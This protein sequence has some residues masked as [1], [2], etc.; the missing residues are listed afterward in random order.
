MKILVIGLGQL[1][2]DLI[3]VLGPSHQV[4]GLDV[5]DVDITDIESVEIV[6][7]TYQSDLVINAAAYTDVEGA[8]DDE[9]GANAVNAIGAGNVAQAS[10]D[11]GI[12]VVLYSTDFV[13]D[14][15]KGSDYVPNDAP[16][17]LSVYGASKWAGEQATI[18]ANPKHFIL[19]TAWLY[20]PGGNNFIEKIIGWA[21]KMDTLR[22]VTDE[23]GSPTHTWDVAEATALLIEGDS[24]G[25]YHVVNKGVCS[26]FELAQAI[27]ELMELEVKLKECMS[28]E[29]PTKAERPE[30]SVLNTDSLEQL[31]GQPMPDWR[32][33]LQRYLT[34]RGKV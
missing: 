33:T 5:P 16:N 13:F 23:A 27:V 9:E 19:R 31:I 4:A 6:L 3:R 30:N 11:R 21:S 8:E 25:V 20:G 24:Y 22:V 14:G 15:K 18:A 29:F 26:R 7:G 32:E 10:A 28:M 1:G 12:P 2:K 34:R 17:P